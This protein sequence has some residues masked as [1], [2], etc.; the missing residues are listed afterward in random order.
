M[1]EREN[2]HRKPEPDAGGN[3]R[4]H[5]ASARGDARAVETLLA[6]GADVH[7][8]NARGETALHRSAL[9]GN[10]ETTQTLINAGAQVNAR[11]RQGDTPLHLAAWSGNHENISAL[12]QAGADRNAKNHNDERPVDV[13][14]SRGHKGVMRQGFKSAQTDKKMAYLDWMKEKLATQQQP[15]AKT[16]QEPNRQAPAAAP[17]QDPAATLSAAQEKTIGE[18]REVMRQ[19]T[20]HMDKGRAPTTPA[21]P[22]GGGNAAQIQKQT[23]QDKTQEAL[24]PTDRNKGQTRLQARSRGRGMER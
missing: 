6:T 9:R 10:R 23:N 14:V 13:A 4:L 24:S 2:T 12:A 18:V 1:A 17:T 15:V 22:D 19:A 5:E 3:T 21:S 7:A 16:S 20:A 11:R 8:R